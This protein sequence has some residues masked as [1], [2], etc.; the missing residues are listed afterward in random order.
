VCCGKQPYHG[1]A[2][3]RGIVKIINHG[4]RTLEK[5]LEISPKLWSIMQKCWMPHPGSRPTMQQVELDLRG[6]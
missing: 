1:Y 2:Y 3:G 6:L 5:P 4:H